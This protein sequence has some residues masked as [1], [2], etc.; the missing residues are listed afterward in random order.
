MGTKGAAINIVC[1]ML[2]YFVYFY[3]LV[4]LGSLSGSFNP[5]SVV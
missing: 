2:R 3:F 1:Y 5:K 4:F